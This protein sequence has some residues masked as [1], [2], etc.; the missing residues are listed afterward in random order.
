M[1]RDACIEDG[2]SKLSTLQR[3]LE[4]ALRKRDAVAGDENSSS[5]ANSM[6][7]VKQLTHFLTQKKS[8]V[9]GPG[10]RKAASTAAA[11]GVCILLPPSA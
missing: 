8:K 4:T 1:L 6:P 5:L 11:A 9:E 10:K 3:A 2:T 7:P